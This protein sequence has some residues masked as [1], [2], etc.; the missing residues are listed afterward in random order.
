M[1]KIEQY[2]RVS[3]NEYVEEQFYDK[4]NAWK[5]RYK[6]RAQ[7]EHEGIKPD[8]DLFSDLDLC[9]L[10]KE[11]LTL[12]EV[13]YNCDAIQYSN[14]AKVVAKIKPVELTDPDLLDDEEANDENEEFV[15]YDS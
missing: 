4:D 2:L 12:Y 7:L 5:N 11:S 9:Q 8:Q 13:N 3:P 6:H 1:S 15:E 14:I 10:D